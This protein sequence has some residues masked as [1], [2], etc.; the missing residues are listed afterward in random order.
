MTVPLDLEETPERVGG[1]VAMMLGLGYT[2]AALSPFILGG[3]RDLTGTFD[4][5]LWVVVGL[6]V[7]LI[8]WV[9]LLERLTRHAAGAT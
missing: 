5:P 3:V 9:A 8:V 1:L 4:G 6:I 7:G 2:L